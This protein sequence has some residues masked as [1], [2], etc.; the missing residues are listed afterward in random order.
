MPQERIDL[1]RAA[2][3]L[4]LRQRR[5]CHALPLLNVN[6]PWNA[7]LLAMLS[8]GV[9]SAASLPLWRRWWPAPGVIWTTPAI[10]RFT[11]NQSPGGRVGGCHWPGC[12]HS[13]RLCAAVVEGPY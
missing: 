13:C 11:N 1:R 6:F 5:I 4:L 8:A 9:V 3:P 12:A 7:Y 10:A 2:R